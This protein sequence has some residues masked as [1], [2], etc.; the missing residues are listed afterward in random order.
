MKRDKQLRLTTDVLE[1]TAR[2]R[3]LRGRQSV[4]VRLSLQSLVR[5][6]TPAR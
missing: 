1:A 2:V 3:G 6:P 4:W 5:L